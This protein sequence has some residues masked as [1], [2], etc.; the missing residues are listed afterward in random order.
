MAGPCASIFVSAACSEIAASVTAQII[1]VVARTVDEDGFWVSS[2]QPVGGTYSGEDRP[3][4]LTI[5]YFHGQSSHPEPTQDELVQ[6]ERFSG[7]APVA[8]IVIC[9][10]CNGGDEHRIL[11]ELLLAFARQ[12]DGTVSFGGEL[13]SLSDD[14]RLRLPG[15][16][17]RVIV[18]DGDRTSGYVISDARFLESWLT[19]DRF[20][21]VK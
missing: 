14:E 7:F 18:Q 13:L 20:R 15:R 1:A 5:D 10:M 12:L 17:S 16:T 6:I 2:T 21:M 9:A 19:H 4:F 3:F 8:E 11:G